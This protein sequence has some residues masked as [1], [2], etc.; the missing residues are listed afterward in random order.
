MK[1]RRQAAILELVSQQ[2][3][4]SQEQ[5]RALLR[6]RGI[7]TTQ[8]TLSRD[9]RDLGLFKA[10]AD[11]PFKAY[12]TYTEDDIVSSDIVTDPSSCTFDA[13]LTKVIGNQVKI[14]GWY[15][16]EWGYSCRLVDLVGLVGRSL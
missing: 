14:I 15:D 5:L 10:A 7:E 13:K 4:T 11:G 1:S 9:I 8:A 16:N 2:E 6:G 3:V 12:L